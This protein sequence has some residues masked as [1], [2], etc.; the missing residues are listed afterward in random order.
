MF[1]NFQNLWWIHG[2]QDKASWCGKGSKKSNSAGAVG[3]KITDQCVCCYVRLDLT[4]KLQNTHGTELENVLRRTSCNMNFAL[5]YCLRWLF[6]ATTEV[7]LT[8]RDCS[9]SEIVPI[10]SVSKRPLVRRHFRW[11]ARGPRE[12]GVG[13][14]AVCSPGGCREI[15]FRLQ[16][17]FCCWLF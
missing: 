15:V 5:K 13:P 12:A 6:D 1:T 16:S 2:Q 9:T 11:P 10:F 17:F 4:A 14:K 3:A 7:A 8:R